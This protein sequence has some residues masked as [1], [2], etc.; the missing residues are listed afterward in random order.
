M[1]NVILLCPDGSGALSHQL[2]N[3]VY[4]SMGGQDL[5]WLGHNEAVCFNV[6]KQR[7]EFS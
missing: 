5:L 1:Y 2:V 7:N 3:S 6:E 4:S